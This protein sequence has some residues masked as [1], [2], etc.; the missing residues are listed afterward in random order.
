MNFPA[1]QQAN[2]API[3]GWPV[4][5]GRGSIHRWHICFGSPGEG[6]GLLHGITSDNGADEVT[7]TDT[8]WAQSGWGTAHHCGAFGTSTVCGMSVRWELHQGETTRA[9]ALTSTGAEWT[10]TVFALIFFIPLHPTQCQCSWQVL[11]PGLLWYDVWSSLDEQGERGRVRGMDG[12]MN[13]YKSGPVLV[14][15]W[16]QQQGEEHWSLA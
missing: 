5:V 11:G 16:I 2:S 15:D 14:V 10:A 9:S 3:S 12:G 4:S 7:G 8:G 1:I 6:I 13:R